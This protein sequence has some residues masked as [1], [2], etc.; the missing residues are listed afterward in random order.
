MKLT[1]IS[2][3]G[4]AIFAVG[5]NAGILPIAGDALAVVQ[6]LPSMF[7]F[8][9]LLSRFDTCGVRIHAPTTQI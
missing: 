8:I 2:Y 9:T 4:A 1:P 6:Q 5:A 3:F 7:Q